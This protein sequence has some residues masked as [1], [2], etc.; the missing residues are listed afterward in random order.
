MGLKTDNSLVDVCM[1]KMEAAIENIASLAVIGNL[2]INQLIE[3]EVVAVII[4][5]VAS[6]EEPKRTMVMAKAKNVRQVV[7]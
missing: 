6:T 7:N 5:K 2:V 1:S 4:A 3:C